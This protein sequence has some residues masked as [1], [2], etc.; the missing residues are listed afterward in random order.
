MARATALPRTFFVMVI[1]ENVDLDTA[2]GATT[3]AEAALRGQDGLGSSTSDWFR[4]I[5]LVA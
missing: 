2:E 1:D 3:L 5:F 4:D